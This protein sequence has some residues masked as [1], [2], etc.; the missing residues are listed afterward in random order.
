EVGTVT[1]KPQQGNPRPRLFRLLRH[2]SIINRMGFNNKGVEYLLKQLP[3]QPRPY[4][5][6][7]NIGKNLT[8]PVAQA[9]SDYQTCFK[10]VYT[11]ADYI[12]INVSSPNTPGLRQLQN[13]DALNELLCGISETRKSLEDQHQYR[14]PVALKISPDLDEKAIPQIADILQAHNVDALIATNTTLNREPVRGHPLANQAGGLSGEAV[15]DRSRHILTSFHTVLQDA[16]PIISVG[17]IASAE[18]AQLRLDMGASLV[19]IYSGLI[20]RG[21]ALVGEIARAVKP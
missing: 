4:V 11:Q 18:E 1:P 17:G 5:L 3:P 2:H 10:A 20:F 9:T 21:P 14:R 7:I 12:S 16:I 19:Q 8:T 13:E 6:G 15:R